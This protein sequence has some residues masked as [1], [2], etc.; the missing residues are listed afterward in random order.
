LAILGVLFVVG[1]VITAKVMPAT[2]ALETKPHLAPTS[3]SVGVSASPS[4]QASG[5]VAL[6]PASGVQNTHALGS[7]GSS[8]VAPGSG[9]TINHTADRG[10]RGCPNRGSD[11]AAAEQP[12]HK[13]EL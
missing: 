3:H 1:L 12:G 5:S 13:L 9:E 11:T 2:I 10:T 6:A 4:G 7:N 8:A